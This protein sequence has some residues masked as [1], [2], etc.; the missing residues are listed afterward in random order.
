MSTND[1]KNYRSNV[2]DLLEE[3]QIS[4]RE[5]TS[6]Q[7][8]QLYELE[9]S[10]CGGRRA[11]VFDSKEQGVTI[12]IRIELPQASSIR[13]RPATSAEALQLLGALTL[14]LQ[15]RNSEARLVSGEQGVEAIMV[16]QQL[17][18]RSIDAKSLSNYFS[19]LQEVVKEIET[20]LALPGQALLDSIIG[21]VRPV[22]AEVIK[23][24][25]PQGAIVVPTFDEAERD[26]M[27]REIQ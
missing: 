25:S 3:A 12:A 5:S 2:S 22:I 4:I 19:Q 27:M 8:G 21:H 20:A 15:G 6:T 13:N 7:G 18:Q 26:R 23:D 17:C 14:S 1:R 9:A 24:K 10:H 11:L 16:S